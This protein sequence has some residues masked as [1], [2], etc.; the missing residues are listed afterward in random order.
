M[1]GSFISVPLLS[2]KYLFLGHDSILLLAVWRWAFANMR[3][4]MAKNTVSWWKEE[5]DQ[6]IQK[7][8]GNIK[9]W[10]KIAVKINL[11]RI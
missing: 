1:A 7:F 3:H 2:Q 9:E 11:E 5:A 8:S 10:F 4:I 6:V